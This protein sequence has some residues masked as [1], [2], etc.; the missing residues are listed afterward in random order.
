MT[1]KLAPYRLRIATQNG[2]HHRPVY[3]YIVRQGDR[4]C[5]MSG[6]ETPLALSNLIHEDAAAVR[7]QLEDAL[8]GSDAAQA[9]RA[10][11]A[12]QWQQNKPMM[13]K[14]EVLT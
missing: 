6:S 5:Y 10:V 11:L 8:C 2:S 4:V 14:V 1:S 9:L 3:T 7:F 12:V 13:P